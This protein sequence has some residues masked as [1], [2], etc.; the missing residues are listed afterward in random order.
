MPYDWPIAE[1]EIFTQRFGSMSVSELRKILFAV[2]LT[3]HSGNTNYELGRQ[4]GLTANQV[5]NLKM[6]AN[7][8]LDDA[9]H[10]RALAQ[11]SLCR[12]FA[13]TLVEYQQVHNRIAVQIDDPIALGYLA[14]AL[15]S[16]GVFRDCDARNGHV[17]VPV[18]C[19]GELLKA[20]FP[21]I[22]EGEI[23]KR[24]KQLVPE[25][26]CGSGLGAA[27]FFGRLAGWISTAES[28]IAVAQ[29]LASCIMPL[30]G[31]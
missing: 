8:L 28:G 19:F 25:Y 7:L 3:E 17:A 14:A 6:G 1:R 22:D 10:T 11:Q 20:A 4:L 27:G 13:K 31:M 24:F 30:L 9:E 15:E 21:S 18:D 26:D 12:A 5:K 23:E 2:F 16:K 29:A